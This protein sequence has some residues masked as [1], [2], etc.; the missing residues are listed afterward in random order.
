MSDRMMRGVSIGINMM[1][2]TVRK[3]TATCQNNDRREFNPSIR[4]G[5]SDRLRPGSIEPI[6]SHD[7]SPIIE[8]DTYWFARQVTYHLNRH[9]LVRTILS[10]AHHFWIPYCLVIDLFF[11]LFFWLQRTPIPTYVCANTPVFSL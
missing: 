1:H 5:R 3:M 4:I 7:R 11:F 10:A 8:I 2:M 9:L 6:G